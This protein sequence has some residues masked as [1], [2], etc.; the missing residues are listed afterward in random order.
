M[1]N[2]FKII[3]NVFKAIG[4]FL[5]R[6][7][8]DKFIGQYISVAIEVVNELAAVHSNE[9]FHK[10]KDKAFETIRDRIGKPVADNWIALLLGFAFE[11]FKAAQEK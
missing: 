1:A 10:W 11:H 5:T 8:L 6:S 9:E 2:P 7:G 4:R 3:V